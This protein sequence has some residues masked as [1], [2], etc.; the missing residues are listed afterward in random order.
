MTPYALFA[1]L[2][3]VRP[4]TAT[5]LLWIAATAVLLVP[6]YLGDF[7]HC[8]RKG[9]DSDIWSFVAFLP[10]FL[11]WIVALFLSKFGNSQP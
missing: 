7:H 3:F 9:T 5:A 2:F 10:A 6:L 11:A 8:D 4:R 1:G